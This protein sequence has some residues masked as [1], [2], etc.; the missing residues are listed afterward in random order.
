MKRRE[1][2]AGLGSAAA[3]PVVARGQQQALPVVG[4]LSSLSSQDLTLVI[5]AF[6]DGLKQTGY[7]EGRNTKIEYRWADGHYER[8]PGLASDL[9]QH[10]VAVVAAISGTPAALAAK[11][12]TTTIPI[13]FAIGGDPVAPG[14]V[15]NLSR[16]GGNVTG[17][18]FYT[19]PVV[20][21][22]LEVARELAPHG[23]TIGVFVNPDNSP[24]VIE[25]KD[26]AHR[27]YRSRAAH[28]D[29]ECRH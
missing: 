3:W 14:L 2:I 11:A 27:R 18:S 6:H 24:S 23:T 28:R 8:L 29:H 19:S 17:A 5:P 12:A 16:P 22:R 13:V 10:Q 4:F 20:T 9:V 26:A 21:K 1:F 15:T 25:G 7:V